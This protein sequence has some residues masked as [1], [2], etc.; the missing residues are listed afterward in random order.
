MRFPGHG[1]LRA[2]S[3]TEYACHTRSSGFTGHFLVTFFYD[4]SENVLP[5]R[6]ACAIPVVG[7][8]HAH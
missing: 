6:M 8:K 5:V 3:P 7:T 4:F 2:P 1:P